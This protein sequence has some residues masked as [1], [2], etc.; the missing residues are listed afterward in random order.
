M[1]TSV[2]KVFYP[3]VIGTDQSLDRLNARRIFLSRIDNKK[4]HSIN[5]VA[6]EFMKMIIQLF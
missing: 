1:V 2:Y 6:G 3:T 4:L 5:Q